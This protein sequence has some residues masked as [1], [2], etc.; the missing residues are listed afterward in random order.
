M[1]DAIRTVMSDMDACGSDRIAH[2]RLELL[3]IE[4]NDGFGSFRP[5]AQRYSDLWP[6]LPLVA[7]REIHSWPPARRPW[8]RDLLFP[9]CDLSWVSSA[10]G[11]S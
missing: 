3:G 6:V 2:R 5:S 8:T 9:V 1:E 4:F 10:A 7:L 11:T